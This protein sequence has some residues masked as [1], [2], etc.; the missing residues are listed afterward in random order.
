MGETDSAKAAPAADAGRAEITIAAVRALIAQAAPRWPEL[1]DDVLAPIARACNQEMRRQAVQA[2]MQAGHGEALR[3]L[4]GA[5]QRAHTGAQTV[6]DEIPGLMKAIETRMRDTDTV[7]ECQLRLAADSTDNSE[8]CAVA[9]A[10]SRQDAE[11]YEALLQAQRALK[12]LRPYL[13]SPRQQGGQPAP[14]ATF[15]ERIAVH[16]QMALKHRGVEVS[17]VKDNGPLARVLELL[18]G[19]VFRDAVSASAI[20]SGLKRRKPKKGGADL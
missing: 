6:L 19:A 14:W 12:R 13:E 9:A 2:V 15:V 11:Q 18:V 8:L 3:S 10:W 4:R 5:I 7:I 16:L 20:A 17:L 1:E